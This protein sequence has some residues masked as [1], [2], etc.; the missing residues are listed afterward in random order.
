[1]KEL[2][3]LR[4][5]LVSAERRFDEAV[6][7]RAQ[8]KAQLDAAKE[9]LRSSPATV[10]GVED[11]AAFVLQNKAI[12]FVLKSIEMQMSA[13]QARLK[14]AERRLSELGVKMGR[15]I[16]EAA[17]LKSIVDK[18][19]EILPDL[20]DKLGLGMLGELDADF[21][22]T[23]NPTVQTSWTAV[24]LPDGGWIDTSK[25]AAL[26]RGEFPTPDL[27][28][29][30]LVLRGIPLTSK[31]TRGW[32]E[33]RNRQSPTDSASFA[34]SRRFTDWFGTDR[35]LKELAAAAAT[36]GKSSSAAADEARQQFVLE[37][38]DFISWARAVGGEEA[39]A[40]AGEIVLAVL[41][42]KA[43]RP[44]GRSF[45]SSLS[46]VTYRVETSFDGS[47][48]G[49]IGRELH[50]LAPAELKRVK[51]SHDEHHAGFAARLIAPAK[52]K[53]P[54]ELA[55][56]YV[57]RLRE[58]LDPV[59]EIKRLLEKI[60]LDKD[61]VEWLTKIDRRDIGSALAERL[62]KV[63]VGPDESAFLAE[64]VNAPNRPTAAP[65]G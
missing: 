47:K 4:P 53:S 56:A 38:A 37:W 25:L 50:R 54:R 33:W 22:L 40:A 62:A 48:F 30:E 20:L 10:K 36:G 43:P 11:A 21:R 41:A 60:D 63:L 9:Q 44:E 31:T 58:R 51:A 5:Q 23:F 61:T 14:D 52:A 1:M 18:A 65:T 57:A 2:E 12:V 19:F 16:V 34:S 64:L 39:R 15:K 29:L 45:S 6:A 3:T 13:A 42:R 55:E 35:A 26:Q 7:H 27:H 8:L 32:E 28:P 59:A 24:R 46:A 17:G 49:P